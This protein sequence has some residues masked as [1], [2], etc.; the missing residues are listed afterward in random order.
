MT[1]LDNIIYYGTVE[2][3]IR[4]PASYLRS[5]FFFSTLSLCPLGFWH[6]GARVYIYSSS[7]VETQNY[8]S[9]AEA[10]ATL[11]HI[12]KNMGTYSICLFS[13][14]KIILIRTQWGYFTHSIIIHDYHLLLFQYIVVR[15]SSCRT[16]AWINM[17]RT[18]F[19]KVLVNN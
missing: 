17:T 18:L 7:H 4:R 5:S 14:L 9:S 2:A 6:F 8:A 10:H 11:S 19:S 13:H 1:H 3:D 12:G 16:K 15:R